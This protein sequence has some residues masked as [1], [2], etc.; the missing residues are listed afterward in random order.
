MDP[1]FVVVVM[2]A[3][4]L[5]GLV[6]ARLRSGPDRTDR[7]LGDRSASCLGTGGHVPERDNDKSQR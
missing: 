2:A 7:V 1:I 3:I 4:F 5:W 6:A